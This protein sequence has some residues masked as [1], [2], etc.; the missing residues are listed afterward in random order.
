M[1]AFITVGTTEFDQLIEIINQE[2][3]QN[4]FK[5]LNITQLTI[6]YGKGKTVPLPQEGMIINSFTLKPSILEE[7]SSADLIITHAGAGSVREALERKKPTIVVI[8]D[9]LMHNHQTEMAKKLS[10]LNAVTYCSSPNELQ[11]ILKT[12]RIEQ[13]KNI[14]LEGKK[15][16]EFIAECLANW[17]DI[18][19]KQ[20]E[21][22]KKNVCVVLGSGGHTMEMMHVLNPFDNEYHDQLN[23]Y[24]VIVAETD[25]ISQKKMEN[26]KTEKKFH[27]IP[28][29]RQVGQSYFT[30]IF[31]TLYSLLVCFKMMWTIHADVLICNGPGTCVP[32]CIACWLFNLLRKKKTKIIYLESVCRVTSLSLTGKILK[33]LTDV[34]VVQWEELKPLNKKAVVHHFF[35]SVE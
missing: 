5:Q 26:I 1:K 19:K 22:E 17:C 20:N 6:Q 13:G 30:S 9:K 21:K 7:F 34:F 31:T 16:E 25:K 10:E 8:N 24:D 27:T 15:H 2:E 3:T 12:F 14:I 29:S 23:Q 28:R 33:W 4:L 35:Y 32:V 18:E 11:T